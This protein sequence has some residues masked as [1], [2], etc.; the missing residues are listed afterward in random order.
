M[1]HLIVILPG[2][3]VIVP[4]VFELL[5]VV[6]VRGLEDALDSWLRAMVFS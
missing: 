5:V 1:P 3:R 6:L 2:H 4:F